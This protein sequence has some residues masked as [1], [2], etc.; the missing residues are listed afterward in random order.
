MQDYG[1]IAAFLDSGVSMVGASADDQLM[2]E[3]FRAWGAA[4]DRSGVLRALISSDAGRTFERVAEGTKLCMTF[5]DPLNLRSMQVKGR[6][7][8]AAEAPGPAD[9]ALLRRHEELFLPKAPLNGTP[10]ALIDAVRP[11][12]FFAVSIVLEEAYDQ[13]PGTMAGRP[14]DEDP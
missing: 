13:T 2:P 3:V 5:A 10:P 1:A 4:V 8:G 7:V 12:S 6:C 9:L 14:L 11:R